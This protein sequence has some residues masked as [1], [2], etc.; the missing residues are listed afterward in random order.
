M[1]SAGG[2]VGYMN[3]TK[4]QIHDYKL[5]KPFEKKGKTLYAA[6]AFLATDNKYEYQYI[7]DIT[8][9]KNMKYLKGYIKR[10]Y[11]GSKELT[12]WGQALGSLKNQ[13]V[14]APNIR[15][16]SFVNKQRYVG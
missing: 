15:Y 5:I 12:T 6:V 7:I 11:K 16:L 10:V 2:K 3:I 9:K 1:D 13:I 8:D 14:S 4:V